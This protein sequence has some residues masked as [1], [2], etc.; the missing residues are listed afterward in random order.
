[1]YWLMNAIYLVDRFGQR[2]VMASAARRMPRGAQSS[3]KKTSN[4]ELECKSDAS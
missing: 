3:P 4:I 1:M 2:I